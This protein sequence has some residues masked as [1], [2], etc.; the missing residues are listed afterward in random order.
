[1]RL[2][3]VHSLEIIGAL[4]YSGVGREDKQ[5]IQNIIIY[6][7][8]IAMVILP[9]L[10]YFFAVG[11][12]VPYGEAIF[13]VVTQMEKVIDLRIF[14]SIPRTIIDIVPIMFNPT[15]ENFC[16]VTPAY[17]YTFLLI[18]VIY[19]NLK[20]K[21]VFIVCPSVIAIGLY[22]LGLFATAFRN[23][24][25]SQLEMAL[26]PEKILLFFLVEE[27]YMILREKKILI[28]KRLKAPHMF[29]K[30][31]W[32]ERFQFFGILFLFTGL[33]M[34]TLGYSYMR[35][36]KR[37]IAW[38]VAKYRLQGKDAAELSPLY[39]QPQRTLNL[40]RGGQI[41]VPLK[42]AHELE[43]VTHFIQEN[44][45]EKEKVLV[46]PEMGI[47]Y[48]FFN[49]PFIHRFPIATFSWFQDE[50]HKE[51]IKNL[52]TLKPN[53]AIIPKELDVLAF[54]DYFVNINNKKKYSDVMSLID[55]NYSPVKETEK[56]IIL[57]RKKEPNK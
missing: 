36:N 3:F 24:W 40:E 54:R 2:V 1:M 49:R 35:F 28:G 51:F 41:V 55:D 42:Q 5:N 50:W 4:L 26:Q 45:E 44:T 43:G 38:R 8:S 48:F 33:L 34:S 19:R 29:R 22:G 10:A 16:H 7:V 23:I 31:I 39:G 25:G 27:V 53:Y 56:S 11:A 52:Q 57:K 21:Q 15:A 18:F 46:Y 12:I 13:A 6:F 30:N 32:I 17:L 9:F 20:K 37:F 14:S 47:Y